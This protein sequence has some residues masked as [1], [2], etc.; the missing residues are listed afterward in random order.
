MAGFDAAWDAP[1]WDAHAQDDFTGPTEYRPGEWHEAFGERVHGGVGEPGPGSPVRPPARKRPRTDYEWQSEPRPEVYNSLA[2][3]KS[4]VQG[5]GKQ[6][7]VKCSV[8][9]SGGGQLLICD[10]HENCSNVVKVVPML[11][12][13]PVTGALAT[14][15]RIFDSRIQ[16]STMDG[17]KAS[18]VLDPRLKNSVYVLVMN[19]KQARTIIGSCSALPEAKRDA[20]PPP[21]EAVIKHVRKEWKLASKTKWRVETISDMLGIADAWLVAAD[22]WPKWDSLGRNDMFTVPVPPRAGGRNVKAFVWS[23]K[24]FTD[25]VGACVGVQRQGVKF[26]IATDGTFKFHWGGWVVLSVGTYEVHIDPQNREARHTYRPFLFMLCPKESTETYSALFSALT[27]HAKLCFDNVDLKPFLINIDKSSAAYAAARAEWPEIQSMTDYFHCTQNVKK[28]SHKLKHLTWQEVKADLREIHKAKSPAAARVLAELTKRVWLHKGEADLVQYLYGPDG[29]FSEKWFTWYIS[30][31]EHGLVPSTQALES[32]HKQLKQAAF[33]GKYATTDFLLETGFPALCV[34]MADF[35]VRPEQEVLTMS[36]D[37]PQEYMVM[38]A[39]SFAHADVRSPPSWLPDSDSAAAAVHYTNT[40]AT[41]GVPITQPR[42]D[43]MT[44]AVKGWIGRYTGASLWEF[45]ENAGVWGHPKVKV[46]K[47]ANP[48]DVRAVYVADLA[49]LHEVCTS[50]GRAPR[51]PCKSS[52]A[53]CWCGHGVLVSFGVNRVAE[54]AAP[55]AG[56]KKGGRPVKA[57]A[58]GSYWTRDG[59]EATG[60]TGGAP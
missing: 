37:K 20:I 30:F 4:V 47:R 24:T 19:N 31:S 22:D 38:K 32:F 57:T 12:P 7:K 60:A 56:R 25:N 59:P 51:C 39:A 55:I 50:P 17:P 54:L 28:N 16:H 41:R 53:L 34:A 45:D 43:Q 36:L 23:T 5:E 11:T 29:Y 2:A 44:K 35:A 52:F 13:C 26:S 10:L 40:S 48:A 58:T 14:K 1:T 33:W 9:R 42:I 49:S 18:L 3:A 15:W 21:T 46:P 8:G 27:E 6:Y